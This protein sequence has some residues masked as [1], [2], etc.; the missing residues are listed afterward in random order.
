MVFLAD[1][2]CLSAAQ[3]CS[4]SCRNGGTCVDEQCQCQKGFSGAHCEQRK[5]QPLCL[6]C[7]EAPE[8]NACLGV[9]CLPG[10]HVTCEVLLRSLKSKL[11]IGFT[12]QLWEA[13]GEQCHC[14]SHSSYQMFTRSS[15]SLT[16]F[17]L[18]QNNSL[19]AG[20]KR[21]FLFS[22]QSNEKRIKYGSSYWILSCVGRQARKC[23]IC[24]ALPITAVFT[25]CS[26]LA[27]NKSP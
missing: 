19:T 25:S 27:N 26:N 20:L 11:H 8:I 16:K 5:S 14:A 6:K 10:S 15:F 23:I 13:L 18:P 1:F 2:G 4:I 24:P 3:Q 21:A 9:W 7:S 22:T 17:S 12:K